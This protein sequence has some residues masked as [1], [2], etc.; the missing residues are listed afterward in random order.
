MKS[1]CRLYTIHEAAK[2]LS[3][4]PETVKAWVIKG[5]I[6]AKTIGDELLIPESEVEKAKEIVKIGHSERMRQEAHRQNISHLYKLC[7]HDQF[8]ELSAELDLSEPPQNVR[9]CYAIVKRVLKKDVGQGEK[10]NQ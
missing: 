8:E 6:N 4:H 1:C 3:M 5:A 2:L 7:S 10:V 9:E